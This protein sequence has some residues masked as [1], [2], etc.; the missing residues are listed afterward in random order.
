MLLA[1]IKGHSQAILALL[2]AGADV[3]HQN[4]VMCLSGVQRVVDGVTGGV[5]CVRRVFQGA[6]SL[7]RTESARVCV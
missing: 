4:K 1:T 6:H 3:N 7:V 2:N 5:G